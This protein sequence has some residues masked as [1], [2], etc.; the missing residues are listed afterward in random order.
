MALI[1]INC[2]VFA[3]LQFCTKI[4]TIITKCSTRHASCIIT[5]HTMTVHLKPVSV[6]DSM[7]E[8][9]R[10]L[11]Y[12]FHTIPTSFWLVIFLKIIVHVI[13]SPSKVWQGLLF[14]ML[15]L[16]CFEKNETVLMLHLHVSH[17]RTLGC[18]NFS[19]LRRSHV[20]SILYQH[21]TI[22]VWL[23]HENTLLTPTVTIY[24]IISIGHFLRKWI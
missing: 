20:L 23:W 8:P 11:E 22:V 4:R 1:G 6:A 15:M 3:L 19:Y 16:V 9:W 24:C 5:E 7:Q 17:G 14:M 10:T 12:Q 21:T 2:S 13:I 18:G